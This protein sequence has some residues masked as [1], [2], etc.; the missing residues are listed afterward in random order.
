MNRSACLFVACALLLVPGPAMA[1]IAYYKVD[2]LGTDP[3]SGYTLR[4]SGELAFDTTLNDLSPNQFLSID[5]VPHIHNLPDVG[6]A[7]RN[8]SGGAWDANADGHL[9][10]L[11]KVVFLGNNETTFAGAI[12][13]FDAFY[14]FASPDDITKFQ[15]TVLFD[16]PV[17]GTGERLIGTLVPEPAS[18]V[19]AITA[20]GLTGGYLGLRKRFKK[21]TA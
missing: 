11:G 20:L 15:A 4:V 2:F 6:L 18:V 12:L 3:K 14:D 9:Y 7:I 5:V 16:T 19:M 21:S 17:S 1:G 8:G 13:P 10:L